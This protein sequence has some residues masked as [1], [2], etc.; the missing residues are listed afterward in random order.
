MVSDLVST[1]Y[2]VT[3]GQ[4]LNLRCLARRRESRFWP[5]LM[6]EAIVYPLG[7]NLYLS[8]ADCNARVNKDQTK[9]FR[10]ELKPGY[11]FP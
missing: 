6:V 5:R 1:S 4:A 2:P 9:V 3:F 11:R 8:W 7:P 10:C